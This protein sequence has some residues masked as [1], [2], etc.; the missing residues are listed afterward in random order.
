M[1]KDAPKGNFEFL[2]LKLVTIAILLSITEFA[3]AKFTLPPRLS[4]NA[5]TSNYTVG[6]TDLM[7]PLQG[8]GTHN[9]Y[10]NPTLSYATNNQGELD[11]GLGY[12][13]VKNKA[14]IY[15]GYLFG[16]YS[17]VDN[18]ARLW[19]VN[20]GV[21]ILASRWDAHL[22]AYLPMGDRHYDAG[23]G[24]GTPYFSGHAELVNIFQADQYV[25]CGG[26]V[27]FGYQFFPNSSWKG[28]LGSYFFTPARS[29]NVWGGAAG[30]EYWLDSYLKIMG[31]YTYDKLHHSTYAIGL[32]L[33][34]GGTRVRRADPTLEE[35][36]TDPVERHLAELGEG[37]F[38]PTRTNKQFLGTQVLQN[39]IAFFNQTGGPNNDGNGLTLANCTYENPC[40]PTDFSQAGVDTLN[41]L[42]PN[43][44]MYF[45]GGT[46]SK[47]TE[48]VPIN[49]NNG[50]SMHSRTVDYMQ[51]A[52]GSARSLLDVQLALNG[53]NLLEN[54]IVSPHTP[55]DV[56]RNVQGSF[57]INVN[58]SNNQ[59]TGSFINLVSDIGEVHIYGINIFSGA[60]LSIEKST[61]N[62]N[63]LSTKA[64]YGIN[65]DGNSLNMKNTSIYATNPNAGGGAGYQVFA[66]RNGSNGNAVVSGGE[67][68]VANGG[69]ESQVTTGSN[70]I[71]SNTTVC[72][73]K[74]VTVA[75][76]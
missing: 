7:L 20:P 44:R 50:Q 40:G 18:N 71:I 74:G 38:I 45:N 30:L 6:Q 58:G 69:Y 9:L 52:T 47:T 75:C 23:S 43:T 68:N 54:I 29:N 37:S 13:W 72:K 12:R 31:N 35:R 55:G 26:D 22:N 61:V 51:P 48:D 2:F 27:K 15:G 36:I 34:F 3:Y 32:G 33:E 67:L 42:L 53:N 28:Y 63:E 56:P 11:L 5:Y 10:V 70:I 59:I 66:L 14:V 57:A 73:F 39:N 21:E 1:F 65:N 25:G 8:D 76:F 4:A 41:G 62:V 19:V 49:L 16:G 17:R 60:S 24:S 64:A 46:Y